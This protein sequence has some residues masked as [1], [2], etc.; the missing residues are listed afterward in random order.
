MSA[1][2]KNV[3]LAVAGVGLIGRRHAA[4]AAKDALLCAIADPSPAARDV[5]RGCGVPLYGD[6]SELIA[7]ERPDGVIVATPNQRHEADGLACIETGTPVLIEKPLASTVGEAERLVAAA[8]AA[9]IA[10]LVGHHRRYN[11]LIDAAKSIVGTGRVGQIRTVSAH[12]WLRKPDAYFGAS[13]RRTVGA[14]PVFINLIHDIDLLLHLCG[15]ID[16]VQATEALLRR[17]GSVE[18]TAAAVLVFRNGAIGT[19]SVSDSVAAP[20]SWELTAAENPAYPVT[21]SF[22]YMIGGTEASLSIPDLSIWSHRGEPSW[23]SEMVCDRIE[24]AREDPLVRQIRHF[25]A[26]A[27]GDAAPLVTGRD[28][29]KAL[30]VITAIKTAARTRQMQA[31]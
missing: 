28:G 31:L 4:I 11:P 1:L 14:G 21:D 25:A 9:K 22:A 20:W 3:R 2:T 12:C 16:S 23:H 6:V 7:A 29:L 18:D 8:E 27:R 26:V 15:D 19:V 5:A 13:W 30:K 17:G 10:L 24:V